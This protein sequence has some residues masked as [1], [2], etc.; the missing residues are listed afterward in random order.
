MNLSYRRIRKWY[1]YFN[2]SLELRVKA[3]TNWHLLPHFSKYIFPILTF[4][5]GLLYFLSADIYQLLIQEDSFVEWLTFFLL[6]A[7]SLLSFHIASRIKQQYGYQHWFFIFFC[8]FNVLAGLEE[9]SWGQRVIGWETTGV[10]AKYSDQQET[11]LHNTMQGI[12]AIKTKNLALW[13]LFC[14]GVVLPWLAAKTKL[15][16]GWMKPQ[17]FIIPPIFLSLGFLIATLLMCDFP[18]GREEEVGEFFYSLC[19]WL[20]ALHYY[21]LVKHSPIFE[22]KASVSQRK[23]RHRP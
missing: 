3:K 17:Y 20:M 6:L 4:V 11:N 12:F 8:G 22:R 19:F 9:I 23:N 16:A 1:S 7:T 14:Y 21:Q 10:F 18:T 5:F 13:V 15:L 2:S